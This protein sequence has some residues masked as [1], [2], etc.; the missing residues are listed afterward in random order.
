MSGEHGLVWD[1]VSC[2]TSWGKGGDSIAPDE[3][4]H[5]VAWGDLAATAVI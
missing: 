5:A 1:W 4:A 3:A 2:V